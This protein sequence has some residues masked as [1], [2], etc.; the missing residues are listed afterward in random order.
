MIT[1]KAT[2]SIKGSF[3]MSIKGKSGLTL[4]KPGGFPF[5]LPRGVALAFLF[6]ERG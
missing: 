4:P 2:K 3:L 5:S 1:L 6:L